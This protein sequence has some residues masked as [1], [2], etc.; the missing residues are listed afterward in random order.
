MMFATTF[1]PLSLSSYWLKKSEEAP[2]ANKANF[3]GEQLIKSQSPI[4]LTN[5]GARQ[6]QTPGSLAHT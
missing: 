6:L 1:G 4:L 5:N 2:M 3:F